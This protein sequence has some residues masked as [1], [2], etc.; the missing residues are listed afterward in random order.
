[1]AL[2]YADALNEPLLGVEQ[3]RRAIERW[4]GEGDRAAL[5]L[6]LRS[7]ARQ[8]YAQATRWTDNPVYIEDLVAE[9]MIALMR[10]AERF[11]LSREVRFSTYA[12]WWL[13][14]GISEAYTRIS[15]VIDVPSKA[16]GE[17]RSGRRACETQRDALRSARNIVALDPLPS[18]PDDEQLADRLAC[19]DPTP[20]DRL[21]VN[22]SRG[23][24][25]RMLGD[26]LLSLTPTE[27]RI[28]DRRKL[29]DNPCSAE[30]LAA[31][32]GMSVARLRQ[33]ETRALSR[34]R[35]RLL[36]IGFT[37]AMLN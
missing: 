15:A 31:E 26:A 30:T 1:M 32:L 18:G 16:F 7:H 25:E 24:A 27:R 6:L 17:A 4:Q 35:R 2:S 36:E 3:E 29:A 10:A 23:A 5:E 11:D 22:S 19:P 28:L 12:S 14:S 33:V 9:G 13:K 37:K 21:V 34:L 20:E 8:A